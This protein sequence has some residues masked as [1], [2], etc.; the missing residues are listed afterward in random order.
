MSCIV[1]VTLARLTTEMAY[2]RLAR[3][4]AL[5]DVIATAHSCIAVPSFRVRGSK[6]RVS[7]RLV[8]ASLIDSTVN[9]P[10]IGPARLSQ[11]FI[12][13]YI[14]QVLDSPW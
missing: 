6:R 8:K 2:E 9:S 14:T 1:S 5:D 3:P 11:A 13:Q 12:G 4:H 10:V 7:S